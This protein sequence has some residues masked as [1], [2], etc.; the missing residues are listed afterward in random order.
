MLQENKII[1]EEYAWERPIDI[2]FVA[3]GNPTG[4]AHVNRI[5]EPL[6]DRL[7]LIPMRLPGEAVEREIMYRERFRVY[8][9]FFL[10]KE[11]AVVTEP[12][13]AGPTALKRRVAAPWWIVEVIAKTSRYTRDCPNIDRG[14]S[15][16]GSIKALDHTYSSTEMRGG[17]V[18]NLADAVEGLQLALRGRIRLR[19]DL[20]GFDDREAALMAQT[21]R[22]VE[23]VMWY[24]VRDVGEKVLAG[25]EGDKSALPE[26]VDSLLASRGSIREGLEA[27]T[28]VSEALDL[29]DEI[30][31][32]DPD[33]LV[34][35]LEDQ[36]RNRI[37]GA[38][39]D[40]IEEYRFS[41]LELL[42]NALL[43]S[44]TASSFSDQSRIF[45]PRRMET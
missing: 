27:S 12:L 15:I 14:A 31:P 16:R 24:A 39:P 36:L 7:E 38:E 22:A 41:A 9:Q 32:S 25:F 17:W 13:Y 18:S 35:G 11:D 21:A 45:V 2:F 19:A 42:A 44:E 5:P 4:F 23:D 6:L 20:L 10:R 34:D 40:V 8:D 3:T 43:A 30:G 1:L 29:M 26:E 33:Q 28:S 37:E